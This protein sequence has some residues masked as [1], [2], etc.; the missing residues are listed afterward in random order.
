MNCTKA[1]ASIGVIVDFLRLLKFHF[2]KISL[3]SV[4]RES[5]PSHSFSSHS[6]NPRQSVSLL[7]RARVTSQ[8]VVWLPYLCAFFCVLPCPHSFMLRLT[9]FS[10]L[11]FPTIE[12]QIF[13]GVAETR[14]NKKTFGHILESDFYLQPS[15]FEVGI[16][17]ATHKFMSKIVACCGFAAF[18]GFFYY[19]F[20]RVDV[21]CLI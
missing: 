5:S 20:I 8:L 7:L 2:R 9:Y 3:M 15:D 19:F 11:H 16:Q 13:C 17:A 4:R 6:P 12:K 1:N 18:N 21:A 14:G 10:L